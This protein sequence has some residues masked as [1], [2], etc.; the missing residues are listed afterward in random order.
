MFNSLTGTITYK[1]DGYIYISTG[2]IEWDIY[3]PASSVSQLPHIGDEVRIFTYLHHKEDKMIL[4]GFPAEKERS[5]FLDLTTVDGIGPKQALKI[6]S[7][8]TVK[9]FIRILDNESISELTKLPGLGTKT[10]QKIILALKGKL[11]LNDTKAEAKHSDIINALIEMGFEKRKAA[12]AV[13]STLKDIDASLFNKD[14]FEKEI[15]KRSIVL[16]S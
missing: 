12:G 3:F 13:E 1:G 15:F 2:G 8:I 9:E 14:D 6:L 11:K 7:G 10:A 5:L 16:L 4:F